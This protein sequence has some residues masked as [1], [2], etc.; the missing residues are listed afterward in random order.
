MPMVS[1]DRDLIY[2]LCFLGG[3]GLVLLTFGSMGLFSSVVSY[4]YIGGGGDD[5]LGTCGVYWW[6][7]DYA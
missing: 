3:R 2:S 4:R 7:L 6:A 1:R 5:L